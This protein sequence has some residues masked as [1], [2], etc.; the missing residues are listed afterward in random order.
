[1]KNLSDRDLDQLLATAALDDRPA[2][3]AAA[4][5]TI[6]PS[7]HAPNPTTTAPDTPS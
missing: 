7:N 4:A 6:N 2:S 3:W 1:M 5:A